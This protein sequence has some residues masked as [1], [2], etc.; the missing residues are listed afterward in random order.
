[1]S[2]HHALHEASVC[3]VQCHQAD[4]PTCLKD[5]GALRAARGA[6]LPHVHEMTN[7]CAAVDLLLPH[8]HAAWPRRL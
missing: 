7:E 3:P 8:Q 6:T 4:S 2:I 1:M 5:A